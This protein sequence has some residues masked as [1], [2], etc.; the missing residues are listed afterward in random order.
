[1]TPQPCLDTTMMVY[2]FLLG[3]LHWHYPARALYMPLLGCSALRTHTHTHAHIT[4][5]FHHF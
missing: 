1:M 3:T 4:L 5:R 2:G